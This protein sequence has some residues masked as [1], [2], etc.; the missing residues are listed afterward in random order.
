MSENMP[1]DLITGAAGIVGIRMAEELAGMGRRVRIID[2]KRW[3]LYPH[4]TEVIIGDVRD[5][6]VV[7]KAV[8]DV[9]NVYHLSTIINHDRVAPEVFRSVIVQGGET[10]A[11][12]AKEA[13]ANR[14]VVF[15]TT[16]VY[17]HLFS[18]PRFEDGP[19]LPL[20]EYGRAKK[21]LED[22]MFALAE[23]GA[24]VTIVR[25]PV[26]VGPRLQFTPVPRIFQ[27]L[28]HNLPAPLLGD[29]SSRIQFAHVDDVV[30]LAI[31]TT[32][33]DSAVGEAFNV[34]SGG[35]LTYRELMLALREHIGSRS[36]LLPVP[37]RLTLAVMRFANRFT[38]PL[39]FEP[40]QFEI[41]GEDYLL[42]LSK[43]ERLLGWTSK[44][45]NIEAFVD[46][47][48]WYLCMHPYPKPQHLKPRL[49]S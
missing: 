25:P 22:R 16:E 12:C 21:L 18:E 49:P 11:R 20:D 45:T 32:K 5:E 41:I 19:R 35:V 40:G 1:I 9:E 39:F 13:G 34:A 27:L 33:S 37:V 47:Y 4:S 23:N 10:V 3:P 8:R 24:P 31:A 28:R 38:S 17:G 15:T 6:K 7:R 44:R 26:I 36:R 48:D 42:D 14:I 29:G 2:L 46:A 43:A 30:S